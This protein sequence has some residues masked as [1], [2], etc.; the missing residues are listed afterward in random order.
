MHS[1]QI[2]PAYKDKTM[3][4]FVHNNHEYR[5]PKAVAPRLAD[6]VF[7]RSDGSVWWVE[8]GKPIDEIPIEY[9]GNGKA[10]VSFQQPG[11][12]DDFL[13]WMARTVYLLFKGEIPHDHEVV[14]VNKNR[15]DLRPEN[16]EVRPKSASNRG[17]LPRH[18]PK[19]LRPGPVTK[20]R[21]DDEGD[22]P[23]GL[24]VKF[25]PAA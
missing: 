4:S 5:S 11:K 19:V 14:Q 3:K 23:L 13:L 9:N 7:V 1:G 6:Q 18:M 2:I 21:Q 12:P 8:D 25:P 20:A 16:L 22:P 24:V 10:F 17:L 15:G